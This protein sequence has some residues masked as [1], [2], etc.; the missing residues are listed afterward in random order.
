MALEGSLLPIDVLME[1]GAFSSITCLTVVCM[2]DAMLRGRRLLKFI[3]LE[4]PTKIP[5]RL[6]PRLLGAG[7]ADDPCPTFAKAVFA[8]ERTLRSLSFVAFLRAV[9]ASRRIFLLLLF[10]RLLCVCK[11][12]P[13]DEAE[14]RRMVAEPSFRRA[15]ESACMARMSSD[16]AKLNAAD[17]LTFEL[18]PADK[19]FA[20]V[21]ILS[22]D[23]VL[24]ADTESATSIEVQTN[25]RNMRSPFYVV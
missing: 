13:R 5:F 24:G 20:K 4:T 19:R 7:P 11:R 23:A 9:M 21:L 14:M 22:A 16:F 25:Q 10:G 3:G 17:I 8:L 1:R 15:L 18:L 2:I 6:P 12:C